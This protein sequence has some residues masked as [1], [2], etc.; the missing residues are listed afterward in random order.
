AEELA[1]GGNVDGRGPIYL[2]R[3]QGQESLLAARFRLADF[4]VEIAEREFS[5][6]RVSYPPG[7]WIVSPADDRP[8]AELGQAIAA[9]SNELALDFR[10]AGEVPDV[11]RHAAELPR[12]GLWVPWADTDMMGWIRYVLDRQDIA[13]TYL[14]DEDVRAG[15]LNEKVDVIV[16][17]PFSRLDLAGQVHGIAATDGPMPF[18]SSP[19][20][21]S[22]GLPV[23]SDDITGGPG[24]A[25]LAEIEEFVESGGVLLTLGA[26]TTLA[27]EGGLVRGVPRITDSPV[28]T[29]GTELRATFV[30]P[31]HPVAYGYSRETAVFRTNLPVYD[32]PRSWLTMA[33]CTSCLTGPVDEG[34]V[35]L[36]WGGEGDMVVS[37]GMRGES[38]LA[39]H[40][41]ILD[42]PLG[43]GHVVSYNFNGLHRDMNRGDFRL[44]WNAIINWNALPD[45]AEA[46]N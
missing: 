38:E 40:P 41:A 42:T 18:R 7:S 19:E 4:G 44:V 12:L 31:D 13:Y 15:A 10:S 6:G 5:E 9:L 23:A 24:F 11:P 43:E 20:F 27:L 28:F 46:E 36:R 14:R 26:G 25:G 39:G 22:L 17:G 29:P 33:Y 30:R 21:P 8:S 32:S 45:S 34:R 35:V 2:L 3:D 37:G 1:P 16:Y